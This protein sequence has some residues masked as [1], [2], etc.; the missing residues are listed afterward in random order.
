MVR[1][2]RTRFRWLDNEVRVI[3]NP[4]GKAE[5]WESRLRSLLPLYGHRNWIVIADAAYP[6]QSSPGIETL[7]TGGDHSEVLGKVLEAIGAV[8]HVRANVCVDAELKLVTEADAPGVNAL[9]SRI[10]RL[11][12]GKNTRELPHEQIITRLDEA[13]KFFRILILKS[14]LTI[15]YSSVFLEL[16]CGYWSEEAEK[17]LRSGQ[18]TET[19]GTTQAR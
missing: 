7:F 4:D 1:L 16:D 2:F 11:L 5:S 18:A 3:T 19:A 13:G 6:A 14:T 12:A 17:R 8:I 15:P 9:R 10:T